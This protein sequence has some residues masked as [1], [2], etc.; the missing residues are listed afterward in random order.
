MYD[1]D[2]LFLQYITFCLNIKIFLFSL[3]FNGSEKCC[4]ARWGF[5]LQFLLYLAFLATF[6]TFLWMIYARYG[7][8]NMGGQVKIVPNCLLLECFHNRHTASGMDTL[9][10]AVFFPKSC[11]PL[12]PL[13][14]GSLAF[15][16]ATAS[17]TFT[18]CILILY[19]VAS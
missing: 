12:V 11:D 9:T 17:P 10:T 19:V 6:S 7:M 13:H 5:Y 4:S 1:S 14:D 8:I 16:V 18:R 15:R 2:S 3:N